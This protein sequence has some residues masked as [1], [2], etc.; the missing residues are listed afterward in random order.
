MIRVCWP[1]FVP[2]LTHKIISSEYSRNSKY[3]KKHSFLKIQIINISWLW[4][5]NALYSWKIAGCNCPTFF[6]VTRVSNQMEKNSNFFLC[7]TG[8]MQ[9]KSI[10]KVFEKLA[11]QLYFCK[12]C[13]QPTNMSA[14]PCPSHS[15][16]YQGVLFNKQEPVFTQWFPRPHRNVI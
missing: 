10:V 5:Y 6:P 12:K 11:Q 8:I 3:I 16:D 14:F 7:I 1:G 4:K 9:K 13:P 15:S 2:G